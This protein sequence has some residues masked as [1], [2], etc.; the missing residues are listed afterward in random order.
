MQ[1]KT[2]LG[3]M[4]HE[5]IKVMDAKKRENVEAVVT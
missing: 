1:A 3:T 2:R 5:E 4:A